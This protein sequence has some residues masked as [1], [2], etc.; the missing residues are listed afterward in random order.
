MNTP[1]EEHTGH[2]MQYIVEQVI[3]SGF[4]FAQGIVQ[5]EGQDTERSVR[6]VTLLLAMEELHSISK[7]KGKHR[8]P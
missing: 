2:C 8:K 1:V 6:L 4:Q 5:T 7:E 3:S